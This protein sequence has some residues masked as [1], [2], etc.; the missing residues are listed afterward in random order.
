MLQDHLEK[1]III[2]KMF[3]SEPSFAIILVPPF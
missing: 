2:S 1:G 3:W